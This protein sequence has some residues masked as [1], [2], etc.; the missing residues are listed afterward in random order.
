M[1]TRIVL[2]SVLLGITLFTSCKSEGKGEGES[3]LSN[4]VP[5][6]V[7]KEKIAAAQNYLAPPDSNY[8]G[9]YYKKYPNGVIQIR[10][11]FRQGKKTGKWMYFHPNGNLW[12]EAF[13]DSDQMNGE[14]KVYHPNGK[15]F[16]EGFY[17]K[18]KPRG[19]WKFYD[20]T[21]VMVNAK[22]YDSIPSKKK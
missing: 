21:G 15:L 9:D 13:F 12:S 18:D 1:R 5:D 22:N 4:D 3:G 7:S 20:S 6:T 10:G 8:T 16:Y 19:K 2:F 11:F 14:S 17:A